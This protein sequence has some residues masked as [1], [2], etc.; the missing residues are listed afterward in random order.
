VIPAYEYRWAAPL[1]DRYNHFL[2]KKSFA[3][4]RVAGVDSLR[5][6][7]GSVIAAA[8]H[9]CWWDGC[10]DLYLS[11]TFLKRRSYLMMG[12]TELRK[13]KVFSSLGV[14]SPDVRY[15]TG[16]LKRS[17][18]SIFWI[19][20]QGEMLPARAPLEVRDGALLISEKSGAPIV[21]VAHRYEFVRDD[22]P[23]VFIRVGSPITRLRRGDG[24]TLRVAMT[25]L[26]ARVDE[27]IAQQRLDAYEPV[28]VGAET[29]SERLQRLRET[30]A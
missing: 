19:Y 5:S 16:E 9:S 11:R 21:P 20:P 13:Y 12:E 10:V 6:T 14:F 3:R 23:E 26:L 24:E 29:R 7:A 30:R 15:I 8:N 17:P 18:G 25:A 28:L 4:L 2:L 22:H 1:L 27:D